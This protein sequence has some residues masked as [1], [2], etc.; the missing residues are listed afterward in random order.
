[1]TNTKE[2]T[3]FSDRPRAVRAFTMI[4]LMVSLA[5][6]II[7]IAIM[8]PAISLVRE[9]ARRV[10]CGS[11][12]RQLGMG[13]S[14]FAQDNKERLPPSVFLPA[15][16]ANA[17]YLPSLDRMDTIHLDRQEFPGLGAKL[18]DG[19]GHL[20][21]REYITAANLFYCPSHH[22]NFAFANAIDDWRQ[23][24][25][26]R[27]IIV[28]YLYRG[29]GPDES[30]VLYKIPPTAGL[31]TDTLRSYEDLN[32]DGGFNVLQAGLAVN[33]LQ[34]INGQIANDILLRSGNDD[35]NSGNVQ[36]A[37]S[38]LDRTPSD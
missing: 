4:D 33:W 3:R 15:P 7:L 25:P 6:I 32:H 36:D 20:Y 34:D 22:G 12:L 30:R 37:W 28:N 14:M 21:Q 24:D 29:M 8:L 9:S 2:T 18:W 19:M 11:N 38:M 26:D 31:V 23:P 5:I 35:N 17:A 1:M 27:E 13:V 10:I 16:R